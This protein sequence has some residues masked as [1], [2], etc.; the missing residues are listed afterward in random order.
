MTKRVAKPEQ[1][2]IKYIVV[3]ANPKVYDKNKKRDQGKNMILILHT[4][5]VPSPRAAVLAAVG[6]LLLRSK[7]KNM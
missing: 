4:D 6:N 5:N 3:S 7:K 2:E 1:K